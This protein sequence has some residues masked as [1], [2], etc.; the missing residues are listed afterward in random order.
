MKKLFKLSICEIYK[1]FNRFIAIFL[2]VAL[3]TGFLAGL[4]A[5]TPAMRNSIDSYYKETNFMDLRLVST[6]GFDE[7]DIAA[8]KEISGVKNLYAAYSKD[9]KAEFNNE[10]CVA[11]VESLPN[12][13]SG[14]NGNYINSLEVIYG[15]MPK[16]KGECVITVHNAVADESV[17]GTEITVSGEKDTFGEETVTLTV[18]GV[19]S[20][21]RYFSVENETTSVGSGN[22]D[23]FVYTVEEAF[24]L[25]VKTDV[26]L[27]LSLSDKAIS[28]SERYFDEVEKFTDMLKPVSELRIEARY[29]EYRE[30]LSDKIS[31]GK[32]ELSQ[33]R[34]EANAEFEKAESEFAS[35]VSKLDNTS[36]QLKNA[37][38]ALNEQY[39][40]YNTLVTE[41]KNKYEIA[42]L[43]N[44]NESATVASQ[45]AALDKTAEGYEEQYAL[46]LARAEELR[47]ENEVLLATHEAE[48]AALDPMKNELD[49]Q[50]NAL[51]KNENAYL[52]A[53]DELNESYYAYLDEKAKIENEF[54][55]AEKDIADAEEL[56]ATSEAPK[57]YFLGRDQSVSASSFASNVEKINAIAK[58]FPIFF[59]FIAAFVA[60]TTMTRMVEEQRGQIGTLKA[61]GYSDNSIRFKYG[62]YAMAATVGGSVLGLSVGFKVFPTI[63]WNVYTIMYDLPK[64]ISGFNVYYASV[65]FFAMAVCTVGATVIAVN[66]TLK[67]SPS[68]LFLPKAPAPGKRVLLERIGFIWKHISFSKKVTIRNLFRYKKRF[69]L[70]VMGVAGC[71]ALLVTGFGLKDSI[72]AMIPRQFDMI[73]KY[74][75]TVG[76]EEGSDNGDTS[77]NKVANILYENGVLKF[78]RL[79]NETADASVGD[80]TISVTVTAPEDISNFRHFVVLK[81]RKTKEN[82]E[83]ASDSVV[84]CEKLSEQLGV[85]VGGKITVKNSNGKTADLTVTGI[86]ENYVSYVVYISPELYANAFSEDIK[87]TTVV[88]AAYGEK[89]LRDGLSETLYGSG[90]VTMSLYYDEIAQTFGESLKSIDSIVWV[91]IV[92]AAMLAFIVLYNLININI[93]E[94]K[95]E[96][97]TLKVLGFTGRETYSYMSRETLILSVIGTAVGLLLGIA[98]H[99]FVIRTAEVDAVMFAREIETSS[100]MVSAALSILFAVF[101][102]VIMYPKI[103]KIDMVE[104][105]KAGE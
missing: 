56:L 34:E 39:K 91:L 71:T 53:V 79:G 74:N 81:N 28:T 94:R 65:A 87:M 76:L 21:P 92:S 75:L 69:I 48:V 89:E 31:E 46:L 70:T 38:N 72:D 63:I 47:V 3:G 62:L 102:N 45:I 44:D 42:K 33:K 18:V 20:S 1:S 40:Q 17:I 9:V 82:I 101:V 6:F 11:R 43:Q 68:T 19:V 13:L 67:S 103:R 32:L 24:S 27:T 73:Y 104:S 105:L 66:G 90:K 15:R 60:L 37:R 99:A 14:E 54:A 97:A 41:S 55:N 12:D 78:M 4:L 93:T 96:I 26:F 86:T 88:A 80:K 50:S 64:L 77:F 52:N 7:D 36:K 30:M 98:L 16:T 22:V 23:I 8:I 83:L 95:R 59:F 84:I 25:E 85:G 2:I 51:T 58:I 100:F 61:L 29:D 49:K 57:W 35:A 5:T 10:K